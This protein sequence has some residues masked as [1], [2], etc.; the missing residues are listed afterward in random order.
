MIL[1][2]GSPRDVSVL[3]MIPRGDL[4]SGHGE[5]GP[6]HAC[7]RSVT[8]DTTEPNT[9]DIPIR[10]CFIDEEKIPKHYAWILRARVVLSQAT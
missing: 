1:P 3:G 10:E 5:I 7:C 2:R 8:T 6:W 4:K 9:P